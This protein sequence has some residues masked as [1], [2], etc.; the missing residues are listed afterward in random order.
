M[1]HNIRAVALRFFVRP[2][3]SNPQS[4]ASSFLLGA[5]A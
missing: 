3:L 4:V 2:L 5:T 1:F